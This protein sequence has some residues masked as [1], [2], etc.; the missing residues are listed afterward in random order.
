MQ[1]FE[2]KALKA[3]SVVVLKLDAASS[4]D[5]RN[6]ATQQG[7]RVISVHALRQG[8]MPAWRAQRFNLVLFTQE[9]LALLD[10]G[11]SLIE[12][13]ETL[14]EKAHD[15]SQDVLRKLTESLYQGQSLSQA[16]QHF[17]QA[18]PELYVASVRAS[19]KT[20]DIV[21]TLQRFVTYQQQADTI[22]KQIISASIYPAVVFVVGIVVALF[23]LVYLVPKFSR[24]YEDMNSDLPFLSRMLLK[25]GSFASDNMSLVLL[26]IGGM[27]ALA[28]YAASN[29]QARARALTLLWRIQS[30]R[31]RWYLVQLSRL[32]RSAGM[33]LRGGIPAV[34]AFSMVGGLLHPTL[35]PRLDK[36]ISRI[37]EGQPIS[38]VMQ[39]C[40]LT[41]PVAVRML[42]VGEKSGKMGDMMERIA[43]FYDEDTARWVDVFT[44]VFP[45]LLLLIIALFIGT[46]VVSMYMPI[47]ELAGGLQ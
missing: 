39:S 43:L 21:P 44:R 29:A 15:E 2:V 8:W 9:L 24:I 33:L 7:V 46:I 13:V 19:E 36:A 35:R 31:E 18:F 42:R 12:A 32:Y 40:E 22:R 28:I 10:A 5:A 45:P 16:L 6:Q 27:T 4:D 37:R 14:A 30:L 17:P 41:T 23:L 34:T 25:W 3:Q 20:G 47:F 11:L 1:Q 38:L 26:G